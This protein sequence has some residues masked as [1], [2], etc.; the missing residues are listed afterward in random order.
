VAGGT[1]ISAP[2]LA[3]IINNAASKSGTWAASPDAELTK[4]YGEIPD[5]SY[6]TPIVSGFCGLYTGFTA[7]SGGYNFCT[8][9]GAVH[10][11][12]GK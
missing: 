8:G 1:S 11:Y 7:V 3:G 5:A 12:N 6:F 4:I 9:V 10:S 2:S